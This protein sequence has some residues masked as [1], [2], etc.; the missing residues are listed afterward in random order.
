MTPMQNM[1]NMM[2]LQVLDI[3]SVIRTIDGHYLG[4]LPNDIGYNAFIGSP[5][6]HAGSSRNRS[7]KTWNNLSAGEQAAVLAI[8]TNPTDG[9]PIPILNFLGLD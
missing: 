9:S 8:A 1:L 3:D 5:S 4:H 2:N 6:H 7:L